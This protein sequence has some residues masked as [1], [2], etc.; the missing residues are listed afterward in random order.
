VTRATVR[1]VARQLGIPDPIVRWFTEFHYDDPNKIT[2]SGVA[3]PYFGAIYLNRGLSVRD[4]PYVAAHEVAHLGGYD[5]E[6]AADR[7][8]ARFVAE[9]GGGRAASV[10]DVVWRGSG[11]GWR[12]VVVR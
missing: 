4:V 2:L 5:S 3:F 6:D 12:D 10:G 7:F 9:R 8:A 11:A 1:Q